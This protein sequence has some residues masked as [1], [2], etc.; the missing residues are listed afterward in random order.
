[1]GCC[2]SRAVSSSPYPTSAEPTSSSRAITSSQAQ[3]HSAI[4]RPS[5]RGSSHSN[6]PANTQRLDAHINRPLILH[7]WK[8]RNRVWTRSQLD[9]ERRD[10][11]DTRVTGRPEIW[12]TIRVALEILW[13]GGDIDDD[14][15]GVATAGQIFEAA[16]ITV[17]T[18][19]LANGVYDALGAFYSLPE[20]IVS[21]PTNMQE[22]AED[23][24]SSVGGEGGKTADDDELDEEEVL[25]RREEKGKAV[26][27][28]KDLIKV[29]ARLSEGNGA[30]VIVNIGKND[31]VRLLSRKILEEAGITGP[32]RIKIAYMGKILKE[33]QSL[34]AQGW[35]EDHVVNALV[36]G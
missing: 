27:S 26:I 29:K 34:L 23:E 12:Q 14:D 5:T 32:K 25:K 13:T 20:W 22:D 31:S 3:S 9:K 28:A 17:P 6:R 8:S 36:F 35:N 33:N 24:E 19:D 2:S 18:G 1:M 10:F 4:P 15:G 30:D 7:I 16:G 11:F 21:D